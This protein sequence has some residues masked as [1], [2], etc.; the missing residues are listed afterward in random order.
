LASILI[1][2]CFCLFFHFRPK[3]SIAHTNTYKIPKLQEEEEEEEEEEDEKKLAQ[4]L[5]CY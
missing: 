3:S 2:F 4:K 1:F 5:C